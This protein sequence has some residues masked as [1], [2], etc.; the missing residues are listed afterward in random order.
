MKTDVIETSGGIIFDGENDFVLNYDC[1]SSVILGV[2]L[3]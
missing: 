1:R 3:S 2:A